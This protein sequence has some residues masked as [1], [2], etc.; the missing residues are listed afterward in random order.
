MCREPVPSSLKDWSLNSY[1]TIVAVE[2]AFSANCALYVTGMTD[3][4]LE[5]D[6]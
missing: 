4:S 5:E 2:V 1:K 3:V 6:T